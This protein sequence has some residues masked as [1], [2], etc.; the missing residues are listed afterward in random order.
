MPEN[1]LQLHKPKPC[2][3][4]SATLRRIADQVDAGE[5]GD[6]PVT[7]CVVLLGHT[8]AE[9]PT[10]NGDLTQASY[11]TT[12]GAGPRC[13]SFTVRGLMATCLRKWD[14]ATDA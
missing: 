6:W 5:H 4:V 9:V 10:E 7:T 2:A 8:D 11:W 14:S 1:I 3:D 12:F 13:D